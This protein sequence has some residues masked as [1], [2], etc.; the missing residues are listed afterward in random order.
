MLNSRYIHLHQ[1]L[2]LGS[3]WLNQQ[4]HIRPPEGSLKAEGFNEVKTVSPIFRLP[5]LCLA[6]AR[7]A[8]KP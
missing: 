8:S 3:M 6:G 2:G 5:Q 1:A 4:A 7:L